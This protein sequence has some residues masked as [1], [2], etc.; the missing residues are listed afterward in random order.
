MLNCDN[1]KDIIFQLKIIAFRFYISWAFSIVTYCDLTNK[2]CCTEI[3]QS[4]KKCY[5]KEIKNN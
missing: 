1:F 3:N 5:F 2:K 4:K